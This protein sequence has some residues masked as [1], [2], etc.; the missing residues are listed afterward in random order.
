M[1]TNTIVRDEYKGYTYEVRANFS[2]QN[3]TS[4]ILI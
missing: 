4:F 3:L 2:K 1:A